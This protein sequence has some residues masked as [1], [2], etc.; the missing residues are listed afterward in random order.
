LRRKRAKII[1]CFLARARHSRFSKLWSF[2]RALIS[3]WHVGSTCCRG[4]PASDW[5]PPADLVWWSPC[6][7]AFVAPGN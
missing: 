4:L 6:Q 5:Y 3:V 2:V 7:R 1:R